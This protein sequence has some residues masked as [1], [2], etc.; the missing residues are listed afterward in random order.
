MTLCPAS[1]RGSDQSRTNPATLS[2]KR[3]RIVAMVPPV[4]RSSC[5]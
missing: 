4:A 5:R 1:W 3:L 2:D